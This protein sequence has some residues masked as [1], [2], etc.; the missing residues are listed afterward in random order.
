MSKH[1]ASLSSK[2]QIELL[3]DTNW[4]TWSFIMEQYLTVNDLWDIVSGMETEPT[5]T[6]EKAEFLR[7]Q[8]STRARIAIHVTTAQLSTVRLKKDPKKVWDELQQLNRPAGF[9]TCMV[10]RC[11]LFAMKK[12]PG[13]SMSTWITLVH[14]VARQIKE[15]NGDV[16]D[17][18]LVVILTSSLPDSYR[19]LVVQL[20]AM[21]KA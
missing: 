2:A 11:E 5:D 13:I 10:L 18:D 7:K 20:D 14:D 9:G 19:P 1:E 15:L 6:K 17:E 8:R 16:L 21:K 4:E 3:N 12:D